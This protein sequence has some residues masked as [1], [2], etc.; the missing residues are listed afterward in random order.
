MEAVIRIPTPVLR[1]EYAQIQGRSHAENRETFNR[2]ARAWLVKHGL[3]ETPENWVKA[4]RE[5]P[6]PCRRCS[7]TGRFITGTLNGQPT[8]PGGVCFRC[9]GKAWQ[10][11]EDARRNWGA[12]I[13]QRVF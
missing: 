2:L 4:A 1:K 5:V 12:D 13:H 3:P 11:D 7:M 10:N 6:I 9:G 8:G